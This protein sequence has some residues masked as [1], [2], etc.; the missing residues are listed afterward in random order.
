M[1][2]ASQ[3]DGKESVGFLFS[4]P[5]GSIVVGAVVTGEA[6]TVTMGPVPG[7]ALGT[8]HTHPDLRTARGGSSASPGGRPSVDDHD[9]VRSDHVHGVVEQRNST[10]Y[11]SWDEP[12]LVQRK[13]QSRPERRAP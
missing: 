7:D 12:D 4:G 5:D 6:G 1:F 3:S 10:F 11:I 8:L 9:Y 2:K 13:P